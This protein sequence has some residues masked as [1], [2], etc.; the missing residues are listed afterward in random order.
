MNNTSISGKTRF[1]SCLGLILAAAIWGFAF[2]VVKDSLDYIGAVWMVAIRFTLA[3]ICLS[4]I[5]CKRLKKLNS[6]Y[7]KHGIILGIE[8][9][10]GYITQTI[11]C[12]YTTAS[13]NAFLTTIYVILIPLIEWP[14][15]KKK[16]RWF[17]LAAA[18]LSVTG[19]GLLALPAGLSSFARVNKGDF[20]TLLCGLFFALNMI[21]NSRFSQ[22]EDPLVLSVLQFAVSGILGF[23]L[24]PFIDGK[25]DFSIF[26]GTHMV[27]SILY[28]GLLSSM[29]SFVL[30]NVGLKYV[31][32][33]LASLFLSLE[34]VFGVLSSVIFLGDLLTK[35]MWAGCALIFCAILIA[36]VL[37]GFLDSR[38][39]STSI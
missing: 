10:L 21:D 13:K 8:L 7:L 4:I 29:V 20:Y 12:K 26:A 33:P 16:P 3:A 9:G 25:L 2:V 17:V 32:A 15:Y 6:T 5:F 34:S 18:F 23:I 28:L 22:K 38:K 11:G 37:P 19:I 35:K 1:F 31:P 36:E 14:L 24:A 30:Q 39:N 27:I